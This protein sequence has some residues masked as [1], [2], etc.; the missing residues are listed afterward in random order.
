MTVWHAFGPDL[1]GSGKGAPADPG[2]WIHQLA[3]MLKAFK[4][5]LSMRT[6]HMLH[7]TWIVWQASPTL[8][9]YKQKLR[10]SWPVERTRL[11]VRDKITRDHDFSLCEC[12]CGALQDCRMCRQLHSTRP[13][14]PADLG[15]KPCQQISLPSSR[16]RSSAVQTVERSARVPLACLLRLCTYQ[17]EHPIW[18]GH[19]L[20]GTHAISG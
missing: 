20:A 6:G 2:H 18:A 15:P 16:Q 14:Q 11:V 10:P 3:S 13:F 12:R 19:K 8:V 9:T 1:S 7:G 4:S 5:L 17:T